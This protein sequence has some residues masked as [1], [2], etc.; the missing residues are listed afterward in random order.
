MEIVELNK[1]PIANNVKFES[2]SLTWYKMDEILCQ[3]RDLC[4]K[5]EG[6]GL[7]AVQ[8]GLPYNLF[9]AK[10]NGFRFDFFINCQ[11]EGMGEKIDSIEGCLSIK[12]KLYLVKRYNKIVLRG[13]K[14][15]NNELIAIE[16]EFEGFPAII[17]QHEC[18]HGN[19]ILISDVGEFF[20]C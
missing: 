12:N 1:I 16:Q 17:L 10:A 7:H 15:N 19:N 14:Y 2:E 18:D 8:V 13:Y 20:E 11:Y 3:M 5:L 9:V 4:Y 6:L